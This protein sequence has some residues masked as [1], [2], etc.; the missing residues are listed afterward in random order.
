M[1]KSLLKQ[2]LQPIPWTP[3]YSYEEQTCDKGTQDTRLNVGPSSPW[4]QL[5]ALI[6]CC[7]P[8]KLMDSIHHGLHSY[9]P[10]GWYVLSQPFTLNT[11]SGSLNVNCLHKIPVL[12]SYFFYL[13]KASNCYIST[14]PDWHRAQSL[15]WSAICI[16]ELT[17]PRLP[18]ANV[19]LRDYMAMKI[20]VMSV[21]RQSLHSGGSWGPCY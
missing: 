20:V 9:H 1:G 12:N 8:M 3:C 19:W 6:L 15:F 17:L 13:P 2:G 10:Q 7:D 18:T 11:R 5:S 4:T 21:F 16:N 14:K